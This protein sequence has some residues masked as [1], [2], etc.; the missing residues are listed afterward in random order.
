M[1]YSKD[2]QF[3]LSNERDQVL[4]SLKDLQLKAIAIGQ[5]L[6][7]DTR[8]REHLLHGVARRLD[9]MHNTIDNVFTLFPLETLKPLHPTTLANVEIN[10]HAFVMNV[11]GI[12][13]NW[14][15]TYVLCHDLESSIGDHRKIGLFHA[16]TR[17]TLPPPLRA[18]LMSSDMDEWHKKYAKSFR[19]ALAH[20]IPPYV[21]PAQ[22]TPEDSRRY[23]ALEAE[24][25]VCIKQHRW[26]RLTEIEKE[27]A[28]IGEPCFKFLHAY[29]EVT[30]PTVLMLHPQMVTDA[31]A[32]VEFGNLFFAHW[33]EKA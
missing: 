25:I 12:F 15:W 19:D 20:R 11:Y 21:P 24:K 29:T 18:Y 9:V 5:P 33:Q 10:L 31:M 4:Q 6:D 22:F 16:A 1:A 7:V 17:R 14:A 28:D 8:L 27:Q 3:K 26:D 13:D 2:F 32:V 23:N 30:P